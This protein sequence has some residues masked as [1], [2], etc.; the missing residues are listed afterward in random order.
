MVLILKWIFII[1]IKIYQ[2]CISPLLPNA[3][4]FYPTC[5]EYCIQAIDKHGPIKGGILGTKRIC[6]C[7]P[8]S[9][10]SGI[11]LVP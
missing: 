9:G 8:W 11:D 2:W 6:K 1:P 7:H 4:R 10:K 3:C 5:S